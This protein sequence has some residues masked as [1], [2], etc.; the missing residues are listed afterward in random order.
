MIPHR[1]KQSRNVLNG[2]FLRGDSPAVYSFLV[3]I[4]PVMPCAKTFLTALF[5]QATG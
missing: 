3:T 1:G 5:A 4:P 2:L